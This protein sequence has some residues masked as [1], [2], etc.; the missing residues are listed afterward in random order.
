MMLLPGD[1]VDLEATSRTCV[2]AGIDCDGVQRN[3][4][5]RTLGGT[6]NCTNPDP[7]QAALIAFGYMSG[8]ENND[9]P[10]DPMFY[11]P[12]F[13]APSQAFV[14][15]CATLVPTLDEDGMPNLP[16]C[17]GAY[18]E[19]YCGDVDGAINSDLELRG[20]YGDGPPQADVTPPTVL[21]VGIDGDMELRSGTPLP[22]TAI[23]EDDSGLVFVRWTLRADNAALEEFD[24]DGD[25]AICKGHND[26]CEVDFV[27][28]VPYFQDDDGDYGAPEL[29]SAPDGL[30]EVTLEAA[31]LAGN[32]IAP[33]EVTIAIGVSG[34]SSESGTSGVP[35]PD[36]SG[37]A[38]L[39]SGDPSTD[40]DSGEVDDDG[41]TSPEPGDDD[42]GSTTTSAGAT[43]AIASRGCSCDAAGDRSTG[44]H[45]MALLVG[46]LALG[47]RRR[48]AWW[49]FGR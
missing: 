5:G 43:D 30:Y 16:V 2:T 29:T 25:G 13:D 9:E 47:R 44:A 18:H 33:I 23:I 34:G 24:I 14:D 8:L 19:T 12:Q 21:Q 17:V 31:D 22:L 39:E 26:V 49:S 46:M 42:G 36:S 48:R 7:V 20:V 28:M 11:P 45:S 37:G 38:T 15:A 10:T 27:G 40:P 3:D 4:I 41:V 1:V 35:D 32:A 6:T